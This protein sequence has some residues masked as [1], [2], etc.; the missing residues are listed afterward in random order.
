MIA[1]AELILAFA[2]QM[3]PLIAITAA[4]GPALGISVESVASASSKSSLQIKLL[5]QHVFVWIDAPF[6]T[7]LQSFVSSLAFGSDDNP[8]HDGRQILSLEA[9]IIAS[10]VL[11]CMFVPPKEAIALQLMQTSNV[12]RALSHLNKGGSSWNDDLEPLCNL[13]AGEN[14][15]FCIRSDSGRIFHA[16]DVGVS[17]PSF[18][19]ENGGSAV[20]LCI[21]CRPKEISSWEVT[22]E[23]LPV[24]LPDDF[25]IDEGK[26]RIVTLSISS[27]SQLYYNFYLLLFRVILEWI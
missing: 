2:L 25:V 13:V 11:V 19:I 1:T 5:L 21:S 6:I 23:R 18:D 16:A 10:S 20:G 17:T 3:S 12:T 9:S 22:S 14:P 27:D 7:R 4:E 15:L 24:N 26:E 8:V